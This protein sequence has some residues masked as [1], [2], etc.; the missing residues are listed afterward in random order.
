MRYAEYEALVGVRELHVLRGSLPRRAMA[1]VLEW[2]AN[3]QDELLEDW[4]PCSKLQPPKPIQPLTS[5]SSTWSRGVLQEVRIQRRL[6]QEALAQ[7]AGVRPDTIRSLESGT[8]RA[9]RFTTLAGI[10]GVLRCQP[11]DLLEATL[12]P[13]VFPILGGPDEDDILRLRQ[14]EAGPLLDGPAALAALAVPRDD[15]RTAG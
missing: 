2:A 12:E 6:S 7:I 3:H 5:S 10:C 1:L 9:V 14:H 4:D 13:H 8:A 15:A 11:G